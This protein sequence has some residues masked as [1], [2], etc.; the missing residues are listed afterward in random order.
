MTLG[1]K[2]AALRANGKVPLDIVLK[3]TRLSWRSLHL[4]EE[5]E[6]LPDEST[7]QVISGLY[8]ISP[9]YLL[10]DDIEET[11]DPSLGKKAQRLKM[12]SRI[13]GVFFVMYSLLIIFLVFVMEKYEIPFWLLISV[14]GLAAFDFYFYYEKSKR[15]LFSDALG[16]KALREAKLTVVYSLGFALLL[17]LPLMAMDLANEYEN[18]SSAAASLVDPSAYLVSS[19]IP[20]LVISALLALMVHY[21]YA[22]KNIQRISRL[23]IS[24][25]EVASYFLVV[26]AFYETIIIQPSLI[27]LPLLSIIAFISIVPP[28]IIVY[29][30]RQISTSL[31]CL[32]AFAGLTASQLGC[33]IYFELGGFFLA[34]TTL[35]S[36][37]FLMVMIML[38]LLASRDFSLAYYAVGEVLLIA[39]FILEGLLAEGFFLAVNIV[40]VSGMIALATLSFVKIIKNLKKPVKR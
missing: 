9:D 2:I 34:S 18:N 22:N 3:E 39:M 37:G 1:Q 7:L 15:S 5:D 8:K 10:K 17:A 32:S 26:L 35:I 23:W 14:D 31:F 25:L 28:L 33:L 30:N 24:N 6:I 19:I 13:L 40:A 20:I 36:F 38:A 27:S 16:R 11:I 29:A 21:I 4:I 12:A